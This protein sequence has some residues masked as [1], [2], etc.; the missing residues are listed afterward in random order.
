MNTILRLYRSRIGAASEG[1]TLGLLAVVCF[2]LTLPCTRVAVP[3]FG[4]HG[5]T[6]LRAALAGLVAAL[7]L[8]LQRAPW[9]SRAAFRELIVV[10]LGTVLG[11]PLFAALSMNQAPASHGAVVVA[12]VPLLTAIVGSRLVSERLPVRF[13]VASIAG[14]ACVAVFA[15]R[16]A[17]LGLASADVF[18]VLG[19]GSAA[20]G[21]AYGGRLARELGGARVICWA[22]VLALPLSLPAAALEAR[23][24]VAVPPA[25]VVLAMLYLALVSQ[26]GGF[27]LWNRALAVGGIAR[28]SQTQ[29]LQP[30]VTI[31]AAAV[32]A[33]EPLHA[34]LI[35]FAALVAV[36]VAIGRSKGRLNLAPRLLSFK[37]AL[38]TWS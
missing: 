33:G 34:E 2:G 35:G 12:L 24:I 22:L 15:L 18:L 25:G 31:I 19:A 9:P 3:S 8:V 16:G 32:L 26:L 20:I 28:V 1:T 17:R 37:K 10:A 5:V 11:F 14:S 27:F 4:A 7:I 23:R 38:G 36:S 21:Y 13:W 29:L 30:F 6:A